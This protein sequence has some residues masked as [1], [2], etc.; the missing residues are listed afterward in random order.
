M[1]E[2]QEQKQQIMKK[3]LIV[4]KKILNEVFLRENIFDCN[5]LEKNLLIF[6]GK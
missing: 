6:N 5:K 2:K 3:G 1:F 4:L